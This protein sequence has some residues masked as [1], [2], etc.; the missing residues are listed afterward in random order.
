MDHKFQHLNEEI[1]FTSERI[2]S[3]IFGSVLRI[4]YR[5]Y[6]LFPEEERFG[7]KKVLVTFYKIK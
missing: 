2:F 1:A 7:V 3:V 4:Q 5:R 6:S